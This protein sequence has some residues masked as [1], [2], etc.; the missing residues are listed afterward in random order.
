MAKRLRKPTI[1]M[2]WAGQKGNKFRRWVVNVDGNNY[3]HPE[4]RTAAYRQ[5]N[6]AIRSYN[7]RKKY[8][9]RK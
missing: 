4:N 8:N 5:Y 6:A 1:K 2:D 9:K 7:K 3:Y